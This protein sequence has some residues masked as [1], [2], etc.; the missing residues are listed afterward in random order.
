MEKF[1]FGAEV[2]FT[3]PER[4]LQAVT[5]A[6]LTQPIAAGGVLQAAILRIAPNGRIGRHPATT[7]QILAV[8]DGGGEV[9][10]SSDVLESV[11]KGDAVYFAEGEQHEIRTTE[12]LTAL[13][14]E[15]PGLAPF[16][17]KS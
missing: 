3:P 8:L 16:R 17:G 12:G 4:L 13:V 7:P 10:G 2:A 5:V 1:S 14:L 9:S 6:P 11:A 15:A